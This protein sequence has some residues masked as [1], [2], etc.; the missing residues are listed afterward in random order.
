VVVYSIFLGA[1]DTSPAISLAGELELGAYQR[2]LDVADSSIPDLARAV[3]R[4]RHYEL[5]I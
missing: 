5:A 2:P 4:G 1:S 3:V